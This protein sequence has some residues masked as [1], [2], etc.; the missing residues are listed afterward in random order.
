MTRALVTGGAKRL[1][2]AMALY[3]A[4][5]GHDVAVHYASSEADAP[6]R[7]WPRSARWG[8]RPS[9]LQADLLDEAQ[10]EALLPRAAEALGGTDP[11]AGQQRLDL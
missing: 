5:R 8:R 2:R 4:Q 9:A 7:S 1:G 3:L 6:K 11:D 10:V